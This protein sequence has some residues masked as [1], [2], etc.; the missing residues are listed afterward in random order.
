[1]KRILYLALATAAALM[2]VTACGDDDDGNG[3]SN[4]SSDEPGPNF[5]LADVEALVQKQIDNVNAGLETGDPAG[6]DDEE[7]REVLDDMVLLFADVPDGLQPLGGSYSTNADAAAG[8]G[9]GPSE[10]QLDEWGRIL[11]YRID[12]QR[13]SPSESAS[14]TAI[15][16][17]ISVYED[18]DGAQL[19][20][21]D[22][23]ALAESADWQQSHT[24]LEEFEQKVLSPDLPVDGL[25]WIRLSGYQQTG[26]NTR[27]FV[28]DDQIIFRIGQ[29]WAFIGAVSTGRPS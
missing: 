20:F 6:L 2:L 24:E 17:S 13:T 19:S 28:T 10:Q 3:S 4:G 23:V 9:A 11:G 25:F 5:L 15:S 22:R 7:L 8:L 12:F 16:T 29:A 18:A 14:V 21:D 1:M 27:A 26:V